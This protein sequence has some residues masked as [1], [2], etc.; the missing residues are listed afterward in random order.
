MSEQDE[1]SAEG[2]TV[3][4]ISDT[5]GLLRDGVPEIFKGVEMI[6]HAGDIGG[7]SILHALEKIAPVTAVRGNMDSGIIAAF[8]NEAE[9]FSFGGFSFHVRHDLLKLNIDPAA[10]GV[11]M[12]ITGHTH[13]PELKTENGVL[14]LNPGSAGPERPKKPISL[15]R[16]SLRNGKLSAR[17]FYL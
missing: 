9:T 10:S 17:H 3:G 12:V 14:Y 2:R 8:L 13:L 1:I 7:R 5:H 16:V 15:A 4:V 11:D 6:V